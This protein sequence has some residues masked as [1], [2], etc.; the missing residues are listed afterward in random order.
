M[1]SSF[2]LLPKYKKCWKCN[3]FTFNIR[4][5][6]GIHYFLCKKCDNL[7]LWNDKTCLSQSKIHV[8]DIEILLTLFLDN[9]TASETYSII[10]YSFVQK[11]MNIKTIRRYFEIFNMIIY[12]YV[13]DKMSTAFLEGEIEIDE[14]HLFKV[15]KSSAP[16]RPYSNSSQWL[17]GL[18]KRGCSDFI[19]F[20]VTKRDSKTLD[21]ILLKHVSINSIIYSDS[22]SVYV[23]NQTLP[24]QSKLEKYGYTHL[25]VNHKIEFVSLAFNYI[26]TN[27][28]ESLWKEIKTYLRR[29]KSTNKFIFTIYRYYYTKI[30]E[31]EAQYEILLKGLHKENI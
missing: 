8:Q 13:E 10:H 19:I 4:F 16:H 21:P 29:M 31:K 7:I 24:K 12:N 25:Y 20:P 9:K 2:S 3:V 28:V 14:T 5:I 26:H 1:E 23:N 22:Y 17:F 6:N 27:T 30:L 15:K 18:R 11:T